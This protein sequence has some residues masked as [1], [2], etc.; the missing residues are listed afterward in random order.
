MSEV[1][2]IGDTHFCHSNIIKYCDRPFGSTEEMNEKLIENWN[3]VVGKQDRVFMMGD[4]AL[5]GKEK[6]IEIG[7]RLKGKKILI[8]GNHEGA[9]LKTY[10]EAGFEMISKY[11]ILFNEFFILSHEPQYVQ[12]N[13]VYANIFAHVHTNPMYKSVSS[14]SFCVSAERINYTPISFEIIKKQ[15]EDYKDV[16]KEEDKEFL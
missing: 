3:K 13:G 16:E 10:Y 9:S 7:K 12:E 1:F 8:L 14:R 11:P 2:M 5:C 15:M 6:I 4:F